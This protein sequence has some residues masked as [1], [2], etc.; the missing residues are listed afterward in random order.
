MHK[1]IKNT[2]NCVKKLIDIL[3]D[4]ILLW[5]GTFYLNNEKVPFPKRWGTRDGL[6]P[7]FPSDINNNTEALSNGDV[8]PIFSSSTL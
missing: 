4:T 8:D 2:N 3:L 5:L 6:V 1:V 7:L